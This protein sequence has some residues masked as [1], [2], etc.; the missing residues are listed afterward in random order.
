[1]QPTPGRTFIVSFL[2]GVVVETDGNQAYPADDD[3]DY[4]GDDD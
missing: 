3:P 2:I 1:M 4:E